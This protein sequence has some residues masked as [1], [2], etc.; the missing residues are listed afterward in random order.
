M[1]DIFLLDM[2][3]TLLDF[4]RAERENLSRTLSAFGVTVDGDT[5]ERFHEIND[6]LWKALERGEITRD[7]LI[8]KRFEILFSEKNISA[9]IPSIAKA[10]FEG[11]AEIAFPF[12]GA[13]EFVK[14]LSERGR[15]YIVTNGAKIKEQ[16]ITSAGF[17]PFLSGVFYSQEIGY[18]KPDVRYAAYV[19][20]HIQGYERSR[21]VWLGDSLTSDMLCAA[22]AGIDFVLFAPRMVPEN[23]SGAYARTYAE[24]LRLFGL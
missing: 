22:Y 5:A 18:N 23:Y 12:E 10:F 13:V 3:D 7:R 6:G 16:Q 4:V 20:S 8:V 2:D 9:D 14:T 19:E 17:S 1:K 24:A 15:V 11:Y 21:A